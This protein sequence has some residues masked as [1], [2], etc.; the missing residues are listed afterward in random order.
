MEACPTSIHEGMDRHNG[1][2]TDSG[3]WFS[4]RRQQW[5][6]PATTRRTL[7]DILLSDMSQSHKDRQCMIPLLSNAQ[8][9]KFIDRKVNWWF[10]R[11]WGEGGTGDI[12]NWAQEEKSSETGRRTMEMYSMIQNCTC[13]MV[14]TANFMLYVFYHHILFLFYFQFLVF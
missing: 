7:E 5:L 11:S 4:L 10:A 13:T 9:I 8:R 12:V 3:I 14:E 1:L 2:H 6:T